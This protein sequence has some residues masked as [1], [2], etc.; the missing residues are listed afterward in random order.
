MSFEA[1]E[2]ITAAENEAKA[3]A[4]AAEQKSRELIS[5]AENEG[6]AAVEAAKSKA[7]GELAELKKRSNEKAMGE[8]EALYRETDSKKENLRAMAEARLEKAAKLVVERIVNS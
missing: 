2:Q 1:I 3:T 5:E 8:A 7:A 6:K 4:A